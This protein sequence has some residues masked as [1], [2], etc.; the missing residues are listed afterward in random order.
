MVS[1]DLMT[2]VNTTCTTVVLYSIHEYQRISVNNTVNQISD[3]FAY[4]T[5]VRTTVSVTGRIH[6]TVVFDMDPFL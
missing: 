1:P 4:T 2:G 3:P 5:A 6:K